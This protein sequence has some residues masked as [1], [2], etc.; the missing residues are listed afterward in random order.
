MV[1]WVPFLSMDLSQNNFHID[2]I[3]KLHYFVP[4]TEMILSPVLKPAFNMLDFQLTDRLSYL[5]WQYKCLRKQ[6]PSDIYNK[7]QI[8]LTV[9]H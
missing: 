2:V 8:K 9:T 4:S 1:S 3:V 6:R 5:H 7:C